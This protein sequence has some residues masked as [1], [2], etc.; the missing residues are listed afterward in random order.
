M[1][2]EELK[3]EAI[4][5]AWGEHYEKLNSSESID[6]D[7]YVNWGK[8]FIQDVKEHP[9]NLGF[10]PE[11]G[12]IWNGTKWK[13]ICLMG[14]HDNNG[15]INVTDKNCL[16]ND[17]LDCYFIFQEGKQKLQSFGVFDKRLNSF[18]SG[19]LKIKNVTHYKPIEKPKPPVY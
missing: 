12:I 18:W 6:S 4:K 2:I 11:N 15:W 10:D 19:A 9:I 5:K 16:P 13:P 7:G 14:V 3:K 17:N 8:H 1:E